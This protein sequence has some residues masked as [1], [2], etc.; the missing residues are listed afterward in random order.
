MTDDLAVRSA[1]AEVEQ[2]VGEEGLWGLVNNAG[3]PG[4]GPLMHIPEQEVRRQFEVNVFGLLRVT[5]ISLPLLGATKNVSHPPGRI[6]NI[7]STRGK[8]A[9]P[10]LGSYSASKHAVEALSDALRR[11]LLLYGVDVI[12][13]EP[14]SIRTPI[15]EKAESIDRSPYEDTDYTPSLKRL[16][17][18]VAEQ[19]HK[20]L[21]VTVVSRV[22][23]LALTVKRPKARYAIPDSRFTR[24]LFPRYLPDCWLDWI[25][26]RFLGMT[27]RVQ[28]RSPSDNAPSSLPGRSSRRWRA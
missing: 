24:W 4:F 6:V 18:D 28:S 23:R 9:Y 19:K 10:M 2:I 13:I 20:A 5:Q 22:I 16:L 3:L 25:I 7:S 11:E 26:S 21:P 14:G 15:W 27:R 1:A 17:E 8:I 12:V